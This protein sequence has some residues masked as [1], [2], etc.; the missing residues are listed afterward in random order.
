MVHFFTDPYK[1]ELIYSAVARYHFYTGN[2]DFKDTLEELFGKRSIIPSLE[3]GSNVQMLAKNLGRHY[4]A[5]K[6]LRENTIFPYYEP[7]LPLDRKQEIIN[8]IYIGNG[9]AIYTR[10]GI[11]AGCICD[12][13][14]IYLLSC[15]C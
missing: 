14:D 7:F 1:D 15:M 4:T 3:I 8:D 6:I 10:L 9:G 11:V 12:K 13:F 2:I 5:G